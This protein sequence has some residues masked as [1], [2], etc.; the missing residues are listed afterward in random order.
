M[1]LLNK[2][3]KTKERVLYVTPLNKDQYLYVL[4]PGMKNVVKVTVN[5]KPIKKIIVKRFEPFEVLLDVSEY[6]EKYTMLDGVN[7]IKIWVD[8]KK[9]D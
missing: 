1:G 3:F 4:G 9:V 8:R 7:I 2:L 6:F 5:D